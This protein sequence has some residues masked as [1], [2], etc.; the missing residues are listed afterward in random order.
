MT[1]KEKNNF[2]DYIQAKANMRDVNNIVFEYNP[3][4][5]VK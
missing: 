5:N 2:K 3:A 4:D 1:L